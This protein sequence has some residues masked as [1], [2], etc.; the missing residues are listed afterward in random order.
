[1]EKLHRKEKLAY[2]VGDM[3][4][5]LAVSSV[6]F[7]YLI[8][9]TDVANLSPVLAGT[10]LMIGRFW[11]AFTDP[12]M[13]WISDHTT[14]RWGKRRPYLFFGAI[15]YIIAYFAIWVIPSFESETYV[16]IYAVIT[17]LLF[18]TCFTVVFVPYTALTAAM[19]DD[20]DERTSLTGY[21]MTLSQL[22]FLFGAAIP[23]ALVVW[24]SSGPGANF[25]ESIG[26]KSFFG[27]WHATEHQGYFI[28][29]FIFSLIMLASL[30]TAFF[31]TRERVAQTISDDKETNFSEAFTY[32]FEVFRLVKENLPFRMS[33][34]IILVTNCAITLI[35]VSVP[36][37]M[38]YAVDLKA[39]RTNVVLILFGCAILSLP[40]WI[41]LTKRYGKAEVY[42]YSM[43]LF[44]LTASSL[45]LIPVGGRELLFFLSIFAGALNGAALLLP[46]AIIPDVVE[47]DQLKSGKRREGLLYGGTTFCYKMASAT[48]IF[49]AGYSLEFAG[50][51][52]NEVQSEGV[53]FTIR[54]LIAL[55]PA[56]LLLVGVAFAI[57]YPITAKE[58]KRILAQIGDGARK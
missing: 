16:F 34:L 8:Y 10:A 14:S 32:L 43:I 46:W 58:H 52:P 23:S 12:I 48:A 37:Y 26:L 7:W 15:T 22:S 36:Y 1:M 47:Y 54:S 3:A 29:A 50:Y 21:R 13:G 5:G 38:E 6:A 9:L 51:I 20:Y 35:A 11:D 19:T 27:S 33:V 4:N 30:W 45:F 44:A 18:N 55:G 56:F 31:G 24:I 49:L 41:W 40:G 42:R 25:I 53:I 2:A 39:D 17:V 57:R 28:V